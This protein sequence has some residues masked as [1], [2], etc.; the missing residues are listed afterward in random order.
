MHAIKTRNAKVRRNPT[1]VA[2]GWI[3]AVAVTPAIVT[4]TVAARADQNPS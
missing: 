2:K 3:A 4:N 1:M